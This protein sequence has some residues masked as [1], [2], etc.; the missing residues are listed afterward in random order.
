[1]VPRK[2]TLTPT[3]ARSI[4]K[5]MFLWGMH[6][7]AIYHLCYNYAQNEKSPRYVGINSL[8]WDRKPMKDLPRVAITPNATTLYGFAVLDLSKEP[9]VITVPGI[10]DH[11]WSVQLHDN[12]A[13]WWHMI[14]SQFNAP[15]PVRRLLTGPNWSGKLPAEFVGADIVQSPS[16]YAG[17]LARVALTDDTDDEIKVAN[18][19]QEHITVMSLSQWIAA[20]R[21]DAKAEDVQLTKGHTPPIPAWKRSRSRGDSRG[22]TS[23]AGPVSC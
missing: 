14:G 5:E 18:A 23:C 3:E 2:P 4:A 12:Y 10:N 22:W 19:I 11:Y 21:K 7:V 16:G 1:M 6:P 20:G 13:R 17:V 9:A 15:G 8:S